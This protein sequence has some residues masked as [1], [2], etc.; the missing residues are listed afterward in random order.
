MSLKGGKQ[1]THNQIDYAKHKEEV[2]HNQIVEAETNRQNV[3][4][5]SETI[6]NNTVVSAEN[7]RHNQ[8]YE[9]ETNRHNVA[10]EQIERDK[11]VINREHYVRQDAVAKQNA[12]ETQRNNKFNNEVDVGKLNVDSRYKSA[13]IETAYSNAAANTRNAGTNALNS[14]N[15]AQ[16]NAWNYEINKE[17]MK[18]G[19]TAVN[20]QA[21]LNRA[22][23]IKTYVDTAGSTLDLANNVI[24]SAS[25]WI[26]GAKAKNYQYSF[27]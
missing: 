22:K 15:A 20:S 25:K 11:N 9:L 23:T 19:N 18:Q 2:R 13:L 1:M 12:N 6:R 16:N 26:T 4:S 5:L 24:G 3:A 17:K 21:N 14:I 8:Q 10:S 27:K 7:A